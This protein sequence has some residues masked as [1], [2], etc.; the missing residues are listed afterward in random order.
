[1]WGFYDGNAN[2]ELSEIKGEHTEEDA[3]APTGQ[4]RSKRNSHWIN[5]FRL[6]TNSFCMHWSSLDVFM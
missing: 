3:V 5:I 1:M 6:Q 4:K 2:K